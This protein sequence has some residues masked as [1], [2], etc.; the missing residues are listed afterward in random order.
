MLRTRSGWRRRAAVDA[1]NTQRLAQLKHG[2][3]TMSCDLSEILQ[4]QCYFFGTYLVEEHIL[5]CWRHEAE[6]A[7]VIFD[8]GA[9]VGIFS[10]AAL[11]V[12]PEAIVHAFEPPPEIAAGLRDTAALNGLDR[13][14]VH[15]TAVSGENGHAA[16]VRC[17]GEWGTNGGMNFIT[18][19]GGDPG[20]ELVSTVTID[21]FCVDY[22]IDHIDPLKLDI[23]GHEYH[24]LA[25]AAHSLSA[26][27]IGTIFLELNWAQE[28]GGVCPATESIRLLEQ[29]GYR[30]STPGRH[31]RWEKSG[32]WLRGLSDVVA[33]RV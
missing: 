21:D 30:F 26:A 23:Q 7:K 18:T 3:L 12:Q 1:Q 22:A 4:R 10:L 16:L 27:R 14:Y 32:V 33:R 13:L 17:R 9:N 20:A 28:A 6:G 31:L 29:A 25:G 24:A 15:E 2:G 8:I 19:A 5:E 11:A